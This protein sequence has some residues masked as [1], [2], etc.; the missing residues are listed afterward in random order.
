VNAS[1]EIVGGT[2]Q[3]I[4]KLSGHDGEPLSDFFDLVIIDEASQVDVA[5]SALIL[6]ALAEEGSV[7]VAGDHLQLAPIHLAEPPEGLNAMVGQLFE[8]FSKER[9]I[10]PVQLTENYRSR[11]EIVT[12]LHRAGYSSSLRAHSPS[13]SSR[14][15]FPLPTSEPDGWPSLLAW[16]PGFSEVLD[17]ARVRAAYVYGDGLS[18]Q[19]NDFEASAIASLIWLLRKSLALGLDNDVDGPSLAP[20]LSVPDDAYFWQRCVGVVTPHR[21]QQG[22]IISRLEQVFPDVE[23][24][25]IR[26]A[27]DTV[28][29]FQG[30]Q[31]EHIF[32]SMAVGDPDMVAQE[33][34][35]LGSLNRF[36]VMVSRA[37]VKVV[38]FCSQ[39]LLDHLPADLDVLDGS[40]LL[41]AYCGMF[42][43]NERPLALPGSPDGTQ[44]IRGTLLW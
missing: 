35:F 40:R 6:S 24:T 38:T 42:G 43:G 7:V 27:V 28:E 21:A 22:L 12:F 11:D 34:E 2:P 1:L 41:K 30:G 37:R 33:E 13:L 20:D 16:D 29:R 32:A 15:A 39:E 26:D 8:Y 25:F 36:N 17:P 23:P 18:G 14:W 10:P 4:A 5:S 9:S 44:V 19:W 31:R 3:Q